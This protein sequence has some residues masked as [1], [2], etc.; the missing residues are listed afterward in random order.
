MFLMGAPDDFMESDRK[1]GEII[2]AQPYDV[3]YDIDVIRQKCPDKNFVDN[4]M[5]D[6]VLMNRD[7]ISDFFKKEFGYV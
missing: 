6:N 7:S 2:K 4:F 1:L 5:F 3:L